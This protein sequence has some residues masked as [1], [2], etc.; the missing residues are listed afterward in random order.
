MTDTILPLSAARVFC[1]GTFGTPRLAHPEGVAVH[2]DGSVWCGTETGDLLRIAPDGSSYEKIGGS[3]GFL[4]GI[5]FDSA[6][7]CYAC[8]LYHRAIF[9]YD[10]ATG[11]FDRF[12]DAGILVPNY[13]VVDE[14][15]GA[16]SVSDSRGEGN[17]GPGIFRFDLAT[18]KGGVWSA[19]DWDFANGMCLDERGSGLYVVESFTGRVRHVAIRPDGSAA[20]ATDA[21]T[22]LGRVLD[23]LALTPDGTLYNSCY[24]PG[25]IY[26]RAPDGT[27][28]VLIEDPYATVLAHPTNVAL[29]GDRLYT[30]N[31]GR[32]HIT[33]IRLA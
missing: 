18:G 16:L 27:V 9:R 8:D 6:G 15:R 30:A 2:A 13:P 31:L 21:V 17:P 5:A 32:W 11:R 28:A 20:P 10:P 24:E 7:R 25:R 1:D 12:A 26:R 23:G 4:L 22:G 3:G 33:E 29:K 19:E 14:A